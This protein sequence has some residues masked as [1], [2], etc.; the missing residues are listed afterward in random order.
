MKTPCSQKVVARA[1]HSGWNV[2][3]SM[4]STTQLWN[5]P[6]EDDEGKGEVGQSDMRLP[7]ASKRMFV[8]ERDEN[9]EKTE[10][11][12]TDGFLTG[13]IHNGHC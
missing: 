2:K 13:F 7:L 5:R 6:S 10:R 8:L 12:T 3:K 4:A 1:V 11:G 9:I